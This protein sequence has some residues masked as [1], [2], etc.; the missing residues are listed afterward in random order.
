MSEPRAEPLSPIDAATL[1]PQLHRLSTEVIATRAGENLLLSSG[2]A[3][4]G[5]SN[6]PRIPRT[7]VLSV[8]RGLSHRGVL[9]ARELAGGAGWEAVSLRIAR[10]K[11]DETV[12]SLLGAAGHEVARRGGR[13]LYLRYPDGSPHSQAI[14]RGGLTR[15]HEE[16]LYALRHRQGNGGAAQFRQA[17]RADRAGVFRLYCKAVPEHVRR[18]E[19]PTSADWRAV[20]DSYDCDREFVLDGEKGLL[21]WA[22]LSERECRMLVEGGHEE[23]D[24]GLLDVA[25]AHLGRHGALVLGEDQANLEHKAAARGYTPLGTRLICARRLAAL[26]PLKE[27]VAVPY[28]VPR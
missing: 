2:L 21:A 13:T 11:D 7:V 6:L 18:N 16:R 17:T 23:A 3:A 20:L 12:T 27:A 28:A 10:D 5:I 26:N 22:G 9:V 19:A 4:T 25:E 8:R 1:W 24:E 15:Y 14:H